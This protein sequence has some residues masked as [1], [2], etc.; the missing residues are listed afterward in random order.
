[1][2][3]ENE[4]RDRA[5][6][7]AAFCRDLNLSMDFILSKLASNA[8][9]IWTI[10]N[11]RVGGQV[12]PTDDIIL[13]LLAVRGAKLV[14]RFERVIPSKRMAVKNNIAET[15]MAETIL[16]LRKGNERD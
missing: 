16:I 12:V 13:E 3:L 10:G 1:M 5:V 7:V 6:R 14:H 9:M 4:P 2:G 11:R 8:Y 15:M